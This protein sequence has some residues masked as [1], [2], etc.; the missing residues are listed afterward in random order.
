MLPDLF[1]RPAERDN[2][3]TASTTTTRRGSRG[4]RATAY[5]RS[6]T[7][8]PT[9]AELHER[10]E[11]AGRGRPPLLRRLA[12]RPR[13]AAHRRP[14]LDG[15]GDLRRRPP[16]AAPTCAG[17]CGARTGTGSASRSRES[18]MLGDRDRRGRRPVPAGHAGAHRRRRTT[19]SSSS[20][21]TATTRRA[22]SPTSAASTCA[23]A[24]ATTS[25]T[26]AT[27]R[28]S[29]CRR[30]TAR[31]PPWHD[32]QV[33]IQGPAVHDVETTFRE[34]WE[35]THPAHP[36]PRAP[37]VEPGPARGPRPPTPG[38]AGAAA[39]VARRRPHRPVQILRTYPVDPAQ[40]LRLRTRG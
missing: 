29:R 36:Q 4:A 10:V 16:G 28:R 33:A 18:R 2:P 8:G 27:A 7:A 14:G 20:C 3:H 23:T 9:S 40:G 11:R 1:L 32:V 34:R 30:R 17:C 24:G 25:S 35:D 5:G 31:A 6:C 37:A 22:T 15:L 39:P 12:R 21:G 26:T 13:P 19:R 38:R